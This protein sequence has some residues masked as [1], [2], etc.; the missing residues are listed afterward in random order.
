[1]HTLM[2]N[3]RPP[4]ELDLTKASNPEKRVQLV[5]VGLGN[6]GWVY[7]CHAD[8]S[9]FRLI[10]IQV[11]KADHGVYSRRSDDV[12]IERSHAIREF[13]KRSAQKG[14]APIKEATQTILGKINYFYI[15]YDVQ[16][17][18]TLQDLYEEPDPLI[19]IDYAIKVAFMIPH[20]WQQ[21]YVGI[22]PSPADIVFD[23]KGDPWLLGLPY[24]RFP[25]IESIFSEPERAFYIAPEYIRGN[26]VLAT[27]RNMDIYAF[28]MLI[29]RCFFHLPPIENPELMLLRAAN[30]SLFEPRHW[31]SSL[32]FW[33][34][35][36]PPMKQLLH[37][38][39][40]MVHYETRIRSAFDP[41]IFAN[42][43]LKQRS[44]MN[45]E[46]AIKSRL[47]AEGRLA[48]Y[49]LIRDI[50]AAQGT[51][52]IL[53]QTGKI[54]AWDLHY[55]IKGMDIFENAI[56]K[57]PSKPE[58]YI[59]QLDVLLSKRAWPEMEKL[60]KENNDLGVQF[61]TKVERNFT[62]VPHG[63]ASDGQYLK[64]AKYYIW[65]NNYH[66]AA[67]LIYEHCLFENGHFIWWNFEARLL[68]VKARLGLGLSKREIETELTR[69]IADLHRAL[70][71]K[72][73][74]EE[75][76]RFLGDQAISLKEFY[77]QR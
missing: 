37:E 12:P 24:W 59:A 18:R 21:L 52:E 34:E 9:C 53:I 47:A 38:L 13:S 17:D 14:I 72:I 73:L 10:P 70:D 67:H 40:R 44:E 61:D 29:L 2:P 6:Q 41:N 49:D 54:T 16:V 22:H 8:G 51:Y 31:Q 3:I 65:R 25:D 74:D 50:L 46:K 11:P 30:G 75:S 23:K 33:L 60:L 76:I 19:R 4:D 58:A 5:K 28:G 57:A 20:W 64:L 63:E 27:N 48:A 43:M 35:H 26:E 45:L 36:L 68:Y 56:R 39:N 55:Y 69:I 66:N 42:K 1:M 71:K 7:R 62:A 15:Y 32:P 77:Q